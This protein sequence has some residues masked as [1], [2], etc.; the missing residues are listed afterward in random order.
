[1][2][3]IKDKNYLNIVNHILENDN[4]RKIDNIEHH[5]TSRLNHSLRVSYYS[6][7]IAKLLKLDYIETA[8]GGLLHDFFI[9]DED[10][11]IIDRFVSTFTHPKLAVATTMK[12]FDIT[13]KEENIIHSH[14]FPIYF[15][16]PKYTE[17]WIVSIVDKIVGSYEFSLK[18]KYKLAYFVN[19]YL[20]LF[21]NR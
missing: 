19:T 5:G 8:T 2:I 1:M 15:S 12:Y 3:Q 4:F 13:K 21:L 10:R 20:F 7:K 6:Y 14:M 9:S 18:Y 16:L 11:N 17:A